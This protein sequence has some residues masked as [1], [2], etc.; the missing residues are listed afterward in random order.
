MKTIKTVEVK[1]E[2][3]HYVPDRSA[4]QE[5]II[6]ISRD[7]KTAIH[8]CLCGCGNQSVTPLTA[9]WQLYEENGKVSLV[10]SILNKNCPNFSHYI[11]TKNKANF[12]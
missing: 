12:V 11:I 10:P 1:P 4:M 8:L 7:F 9:A 6:Y 2:F 3:V 5:G